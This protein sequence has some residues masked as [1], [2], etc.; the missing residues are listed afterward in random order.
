[1]ASSLFEYTALSSRETSYSAAFAWLL[2]R[3]SPVPLTQR[4]AVVAALLGSG[5]GLRPA[6]VTSIAVETEVP[7][8]Q[9]AGAARRQRLDLRIRLQQ[10]RM[11]LPIEI[12][13]ENKLKS[14][15]QP[16][17]LTGYDA[18]LNATAA[19]CSARYKL[20]L[21]L[22]GIEPQSGDGWIGVSYST[23]LRAIRTHVQVEDHSVLELEEALASLV[24][25]VE[26]SSSRRP[27]PLVLFAFGDAVGE[28]RPEMRPLMDYVDEQGLKSAVQRTW[29]ETL[30]SNLQIP[31]QCAVTFAET[32]GQALFNIVTSIREGQ[33]NV[34]AGFQL[35][36]RS[37]K[38]FCQPSPY[39]ETISK[40][41]GRK[42]AGA[43]ER[44]QRN[45][46]MVG[47]M[48]SDRGKGFRSVTVAQLPKGRSVEGWRAAVQ[49][50]LNALGQFLDGP[51]DS[52][53]SESAPRSRQM[54]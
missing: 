18:C 38:L 30:V 32:H 51:S 48:T 39:G 5:K 49:G 17:Q 7:I 35:Q 42:V 1:M 9:E 54:K 46:N 11:T 47:H 21:T 45:L 19:E 8:G 34:D 12:L 26:L 44:L 13:V 24:R 22:T 27:S 52:R 10:K 4:A 43:L 53:P 41:K 50:P 31:K 20:L 2:G 14:C 36:R 25:V 23:L 15:E 40:E 16:G 6:D 37:L 33:E 3:H 28:V 29:L